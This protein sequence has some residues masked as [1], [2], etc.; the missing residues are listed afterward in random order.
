MRQKVERRPW[1]LLLWP[2]R[3]DFYPFPHCRCKRSQRWVC[4]CRTAGPA[5][6]PAERWLRWQRPGG[7]G[8]E[9]GVG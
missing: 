2:E 1:A 8:L 4:P 7:V 3:E 5:C 9:R 6:L